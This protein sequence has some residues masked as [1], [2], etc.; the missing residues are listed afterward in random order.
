MMI[1]GDKDIWANSRPGLLRFIWEQQ[2]GVCI[3]FNLMTSFRNLEILMPQHNWHQVQKTSRRNAPDMMRLHRWCCLHGH[4]RS[5]TKMRKMTKH[6]QRNMPQFTSSD[7]FLTHQWST[8]ALVVF[9]PDVWCQHKYKDPATILFVVV[10]FC[11]VST[12][13]S[14]RK[15]TQIRMPC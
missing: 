5:P 15:K 11:L 2:I 4:L 3:N 7:L 12:A 9:H 13:C 6:M 14:M 10:L 1:S 8:M